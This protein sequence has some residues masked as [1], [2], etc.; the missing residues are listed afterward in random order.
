MPLVI[1]RER[2]EKRISIVMVSATEGT[3]LPSL[4]PANTILAF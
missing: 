4:L 2:C 1:L 3:H